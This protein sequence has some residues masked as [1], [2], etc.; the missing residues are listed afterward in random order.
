MS[1]INCLFVQ[2]VG[3]QRYLGICDNAINRKNEEVNP[4]C[5]APRIF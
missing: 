5:M 4:W 2:L 1:E 3:V